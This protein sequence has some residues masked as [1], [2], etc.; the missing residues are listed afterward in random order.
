MS[1][2]RTVVQSRD[3][4]PELLLPEP[5][6]GISGRLSLVRSVP[7]LAQQV[8]HRVRCHL[9]H[10]VVSRLR[11]VF[12]GLDLLSDLDERVAEAVHLRF[13][14][15]FGRLDHEGVGD[16]PGHGRRVEA[17]VL[18]PLGNV[19][20]LDASALFKLSDVQDELVRAATGRVCVENR[21][22]WRESREDVVGVE[23]RDLRGVSQAGSAWRGLAST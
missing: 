4:G 21:V 7:V 3:A 23:Q 22:M 11:S 17:V 15:G 8:D 14:L 19:D 9:E 10:V 18:Q 5:R 16:G 6:Q 13:A 1:V 20:R 2:E 12:D